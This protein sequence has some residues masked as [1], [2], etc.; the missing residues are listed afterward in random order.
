MTLPLRLAI[1]GS[2]LFAEKIF[3]NA[4]VDFDRAQE[5]QGLGA[6]VREA[7][8]WGFRFLVAL[9]AAVALFTYVRGWENLRIVAASVTASPIRVPWLLAHLALVAV[10][11]PLSYALYRYTATD[12]SFAGIVILWCV[13]GTTAV[14]AALASM[15]SLP[16]WLDAARALGSIRWYAVIAALIG[17]SAMQ[18]TQKLWAP[19]AALTFD[20]TRRLLAPVVPTLTADP[21]NLVLST[22]RFAVQIADVC[23]GL[24]GVGLVLAFAG[25]W[26]FFFRD[27]YIFPRAL[28]LIPAGAAAIFGLNVLR[29]A[30][31][32]LIGDAGFPGVAVYGFH[33]QA[34]WIAFIAVACGL[35]LSS[36]RSSWLNRTAVRPDASL[37]MHNPTAVYLMPLLAVLAA[38]A[39]SRAFSSDFEYLYP[40]TVIA[41]L[42]MFARYRRPLAGIDWGWSWRGLAVG[43]LVFLVWIVAAFLLV[44]AH[45]M[46]AKLAATPWALRAFWILSRIVGSILIVPIAE[47][48]AYRG[49]L[50]R[51]LIKADFESVA[52][53]SVR[54]PALTLTAIV[55]GAAHGALW[56]PGIVA[57]LGFGLIIIRRGRFGEAVAA[58][59]AAN[60]LISVSVLGWHQWQLW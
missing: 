58:H 6:F 52:F 22:G 26:L 25:A 48:L 35:V 30:A 18:M 19:T 43:A 28:L 15:A 49:F 7:Q 33:S 38:G 21:A 31:L 4:F 12:L 34:G 23:S 57:G 59:A 44:P 3:L 55:F 51:R 42:L 50:M 27:E 20:L 2:V 16:L 41:G 5:A 11:V 37:P 46:P 54:W 9:A 8:H 24:E 10:L 36:R 60:A 40:L 32:I 39:V 17:T 47:E 53:K 13:V 56:V 1:L 29:I 45:P 14:L